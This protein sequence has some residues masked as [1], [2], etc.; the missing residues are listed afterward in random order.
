MSQHR[1]TEQQRVFA[2]ALV[3]EGMSQTE[4]AITAGY[5][6][7]TAPAIAS[8]LVKHPKVSMEIERLRERAETRASVTATMSR[9]DVLQALVGLTSASE[10]KPRDRIAAL[11]LISDIE[12]YA[13]PRQSERVTLHASLPAG[14]EGIDRETLRRIAYPAPRPR[15]IAL[16]VVDDSE[17]EVGGGAQSGGA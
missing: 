14:L 5:S 8:Q 13:A 2:R 16:D 15:R 3:L 7:R 6:E 10:V 12:G 1:L 9:E 17:E 4:A 11:K